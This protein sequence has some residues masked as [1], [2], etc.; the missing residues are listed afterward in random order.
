MKIIVL[1]AGK[2]ERLYPLT[3]NMPKSLLDMGNGKT[4]LEEQI[5][6]FQAS[7]VIDEIVLVIGYLADQI[8]AKIKFYKN[9][10]IQIKTIYNPFFDVS[11]N[12][13]SLWF[14]KVEMTEAFLVTNGDNLFSTEVITDFVRS[15][16]DGFFLSIS[17]KNHYDN[18]DM[19]VTLHGELVELVSKEIDP[20]AADAESPGLLLVDGPRAVETFKNELEHLVRDPDHRNSFWLEQLNSFARKGIPVQTWT[21]DGMTKWQE[22]DIHLDVSR[23]KKLIGID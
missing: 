9:L 8:E 3:R 14:A 7:G 19:K 13:M 23:A 16:S 22:V 12:L 1:A 11:N 6:R 18:D 10:G 20:Q 15:N 21:F 2:G 4:L 5:E 17:K